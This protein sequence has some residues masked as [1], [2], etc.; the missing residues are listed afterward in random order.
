MVS[1]IIIGGLSEIRIVYYFK[2]MFTTKR[3]S[4]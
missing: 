3:V 1:S 2:E 4:I